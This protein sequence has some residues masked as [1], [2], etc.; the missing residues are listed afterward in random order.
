MGTIDK[1][2]MLAEQPFT[3]RAYKDG[4]IGLS[5]EGREVKVLRGKEAERFLS[6]VQG[7]DPFEAQLQ[8]ARATG[9]FKRGNERVAKNKRK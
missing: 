7:A 5:C 4:R 1:R 3:Y 8:M 6:R 9:N 2:G